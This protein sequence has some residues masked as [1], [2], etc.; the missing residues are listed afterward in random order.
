[1]IRVSGF[2]VFGVRGIAFG[3]QGFALGVFVVRGVAFGY[4]FS[5]FEVPRFDVSGSG[6]SRIVVFGVSGSGF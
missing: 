4:G 6:F 3:V 1:M 2:G 5:R